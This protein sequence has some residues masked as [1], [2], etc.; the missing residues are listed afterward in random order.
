VLVYTSW[1][2]A[3]LLSPLNRGRYRDQGRVVLHFNFVERE[4]R[5]RKGGVR[6]GDD[7]EW[8]CWMRL[9]S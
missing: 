8:I 9:V 1:R 3:C 2:D 5:K 6:S 4:R 7:W